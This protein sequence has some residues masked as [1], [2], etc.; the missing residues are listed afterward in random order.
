MRVCRFTLEFGDVVVHLRTRSLYHL[1]N[2]IPRGV[3]V[4]AVREYQA[5]GLLDAATVKVSGC[6]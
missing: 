4:E 3:V 1:I 5:T 6:V 2:T